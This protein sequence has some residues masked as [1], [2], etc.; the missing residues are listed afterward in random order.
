MS[1]LQVV[2]RNEIYWHLSWKVHCGLR[3][4]NKTTDVNQ[5]EEIEKRTERGEGSG[6]K[7]RDFMLVNKIVPPGPY[8][9]SQTTTPYYFGPPK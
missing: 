5:N 2:N 6:W 7:K 8:I 4:Q 9:C 1:R 3:E